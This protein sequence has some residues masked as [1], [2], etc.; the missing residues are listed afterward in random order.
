M[1]QTTLLSL[2]GSVVVVSQIPQSPGLIPAGFTLDAHSITRAVGAH[3]TTIECREI[4]RCI[5]TTVEVGA[6]ARPILVVITKDF[7]KQ[8]IAIGPKVDLMRLHDL[9]RDRGV[10]VKIHT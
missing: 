1:W 10:S 9:L 4:T 3:V 6:T 8:T 5:I 2:A 7:K